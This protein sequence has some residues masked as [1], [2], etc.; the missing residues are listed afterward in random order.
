MVTSRVRV[1]AGVLARFG[2]SLVLTTTSGWDHIDVDAA[3]A[4]GVAVARCPE[5][6]RDAVAE[7][8]VHGIGVLLRRMP[9]FERA[10]REGRW[11]RA[12]LPDL[13]PLP[14]AGSP[15]L[16]VG[17]GVIGRHVARILLAHGATVMG[18]Y[19][20]GLPEGVVPVEL[21][22]GLR[23]ARAVTLHCALTPATRGLMSA[24]RIAALARGSVLV[25]TARGPLVEVDAAVDA[26]QSGHLRGCLLDVFPKEPW[27]GLAEAA[28]VEGLVLTPHASGFT[29]DLGTRV[30]REVATALAAGSRIAPCPTG[31]TASGR[32]RAAG[33]PAADRGPG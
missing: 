31:S 32:P 7:Q 15:I 3:I 27:P 20:A 25:N 17:L 28:A 26:V 13:D 16:V 23:R 19:P 9:A 24:A 1:D 6:R 4:R 29:R 18:V 10:A 12:E 11:A 21:D 5:A 2:G 33:R 14:I 8:A 30:A 22:D